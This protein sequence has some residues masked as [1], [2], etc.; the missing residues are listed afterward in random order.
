MA[1][2]SKEIRQFGNERIEVIFR[3]AA[4]PETPVPPPFRQIHYE[5][6][7][8]GTTT[9]PRGTVL[10][11]GGY[12]LLATLYG[13]GM[14]PCP[15]MTGSSFTLIC[16]GPQ[17]DRIFRPSFPGVLTANQCP[18][19][20]RLVSPQELSP[21]Y[22]NLKVQTRGTGATA[23]MLWPTWTH[24]ELTALKAIFTSGEP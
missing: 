21:V 16:S 24:V 4:P 7:K 22:K 6:L 17:M 19:G 9:L 11:E 12:P 20:R 8:P 1:E 3:K 23:D 5:G 18:K 14:F 15:F 10:I 13:S 2:I